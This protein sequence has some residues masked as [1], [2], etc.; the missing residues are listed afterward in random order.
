MGRGPSQ[1]AR[2]C[3]ILGGTTV[4]VSYFFS[5]RPCVPNSSARVDDLEQRLLDYLQNH[6][7]DRFRAKELARRLGLRDRDDYVAFRDLLDRL[8]DA[9]QVR[10][11][12]QLYGYAP[13]RRRKDGNAITGRLI[14]HPQGFGFVAVE[15]QDDDYFVRGSAMGN[16]LDGDL[17]EL[18]VRSA[19]PR[20]GRSVAGEDTRTEAVITNVVERGRTQLVGTFTRRGDSAQ[21]AP[22]DARVQRNVRIKDGDF[23]N[24]AD[25]DKVTV[26]IRDYGETPDD[27]LQGFVTRVLG[28][29]TDPAVRVLALALAQGIRADFPEVVERQAE[30]IPVAIPPDEI[31]RRTDFRQHRVFTIDPVDAKDFDDAIHVTRLKNGNVE[32][33]VHIADVSHFIPEGSALDREAYERATSVYLVDRVI[34]MLPEHLSNGVCSLVPH[35]DRL[36]YSCVMEVTGGGELVGW[37]IHEGVIYSHHRFS[38]E[39]AQ[40]VLDGRDDHPFADD[41][42]LAHETAQALTTRRMAEGAIDFE[43]TEVK[44]LL[45]ENGHAVGV[46]KKA[47]QAT[48]RLIE[49]F[50]L[51]ANRAVATQWRARPFVYRVHEPPKPERIEALADY[52]KPFGLSLPNR[53]GVVEAHDLARLLDRVRGTDEGVVVTQAALRAMSKARYSPHN[54]GHFGLGFSHYTHFTSPIRRYPDLIVHR[55]SKRYFGGKPGADVSTL[56]EQSAHCS[57]QEREAETAE[58]ESVKLKQV[59]FLQDRV[60]EAFDGVVTGAA[61]FG[62]FV[63]LSAVL[64]EGLLHVRELR[65]DRFDY[66]ERRLALVGRFSGQTYR[67]GTPVRVVVLKADVDTRQ[68]D[69]G[70]ADDG[71]APPTTRPAASQKSS[72]KPLTGR[73]GRHANR[74]KKRR[75]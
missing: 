43:Q 47:R 59:E 27:A 12:G 42:R 72:G 73:G 44:I 35:E 51:L 26:A 7:S 52:V 64:A 9:G 71:P 25:G 21:V 8:A 3:R 18:A 15:G 39:G 60:G 62:V 33:G 20:R 67:P 5:G 53:D 28:P 2:M 57:T 66:D 6:G 31:A 45:D 16:A 41:L 14:V 24:A 65:D 30:A 49:E 36:V 11:A 13:L 63:E 10:R 75:R 46:Q 34:P 40:A 38:Y 55:L 29:A 56:E 61:K 32:V 19:D 37:T 74:P 17:V 23:G 22:D 4:V 70:L 68:I 54:A 69:L 48:N 1:R 58:R 50:M